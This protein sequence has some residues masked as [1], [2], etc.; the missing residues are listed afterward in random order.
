M[1][2][3]DR[4]GTSAHQLG[5]GGRLPIEEGQPGP[6]KT[7]KGGKLNAFSITFI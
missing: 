4:L 1:M 7:I 2:N 3:T 6:L 5:L